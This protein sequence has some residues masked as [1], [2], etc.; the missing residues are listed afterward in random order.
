MLNPQSPIP[1]YHQLADILLGW[2]RSG[3][4]LPGSRIPSEHSLSATFRIGRPTVRQGIDILIRKRILM[5]KR[6][7]GTYVRADQAEVDLFSLGGTIASFHRKGI[8]VS[9]QILEPTRLVQLGTDDDNPFAEQSAYFLSRLS[10][11]ENLPVLLEHIYLHP[12]LFAGIDTIDLSGQSLS[13]VVEERY[14][15]KPTSGRQTF[16]IGYLDGEK[17]QHLA[18]SASTPILLVQR[19]L[20]FVPAPNAVF[21]ELYCRTDQF[22]FAQTIGGTAHDG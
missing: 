13:Q 15:L 7:S 20:H 1:L 8:S 21:A 6:G 12:T 2:I 19:L 16:R 17:A 14:Y 3:K 11:V 4:Y 10:L 9:T 18:V 5:R 22:V